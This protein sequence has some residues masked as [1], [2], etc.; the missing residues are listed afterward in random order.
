MRRFIVAAA[1]GGALVVAA[2]A[3]SVTAAPG[4]RTLTVV[5]H[6]DTDFVVDNAP[7]GVDSVGDTLAW[8]NPIYD[9]SDDHQVGRDQGS[10]V[11]T[12]PGMSWECAW[13]T[14]LADGSLTV[15]GPFTDD[16][17]D[18]VLSI[19][20]GTGAYSN[21][22]G[23]MTLHWRNELGTQFDFTFRING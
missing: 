16:G 10:C 3:S 2:L 9:A 5:E 15:E 4:G 7:T 22:R 1:V 8:G 23:E 13:T 18:S 14:I 19:T 17:E 21:V 11:R 12:N 20:G 6:A